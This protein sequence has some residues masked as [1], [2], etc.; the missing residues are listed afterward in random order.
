MSSNG[1]EEETKNICYVKGESAFDH[2][3]IISWLKKFHLGS[4]NLDYQVRSGGSKPLIPK[5]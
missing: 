5:S 3:I 4:R 2:S 1:T